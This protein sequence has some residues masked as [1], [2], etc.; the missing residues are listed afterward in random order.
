MPHMHLRGKDMTYT[1]KYP[2]GRE[3]IALSVPQYDFNWQMQYVLKNP[4]AVSKGSKL[5]VQAHYNNSRSNKFNPNPD[6]WV[7]EG[8][9][10]WE[11]MMTPFFAVLVDTKTD[12]RTIFKF[13]FSV[14]GGG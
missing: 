1:V 8:Q 13:G 10:T 9:M 4:I 3:Q 7:Y 14:A 2:D 6:R 5:H 11:E 12:P